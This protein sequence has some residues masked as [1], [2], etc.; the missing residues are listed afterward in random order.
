MQEDKEFKKKEK[1]IREALYK[2]AIGY[3]AKEVVEEFVLSE[4]GE[5][6]LSKRKV[7]KKHISPDISSA[8]VLLEH[9]DST[10]N[11]NYSNYSDEELEKEKQ[12]L[13]KLLKGVNDDESKV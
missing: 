13:I 2:K 6:K 3:E 4:D 7:T 10:S 8:K 5:M 12:R 11:S 9:I 1:D